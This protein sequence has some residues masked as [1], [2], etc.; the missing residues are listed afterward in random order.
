MPITQLQGFGPTGLSPIAS[1]NHCTDR[2]I[3]IRAAKET[4]RHAPPPIEVRAEQ[5]RPTLVVNSKTS[6]YPGAPNRRRLIGRPPQAIQ[7]PITG[8]HLS[9]AGKSTSLGLA[10]KPYPPPSGPGCEVYAQAI[11][12]EDLEPL[13]RLFI[14]SRRPLA[15]EISVASWDKIVPHRCRLQPRATLEAGGAPR[16]EKVE[17]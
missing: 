17:I 11:W 13:L 4:V 9:P 5:I 8:A 7:G 3:S 1:K 16:H 10:R 6:P 15:T 12:R 14:R 2:A